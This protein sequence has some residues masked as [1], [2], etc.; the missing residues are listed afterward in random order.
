MEVSP[1]VSCKLVIAELYP[2]SLATSAGKDVRIRHVAVIAVLLFCSTSTRTLNEETKMETSDQ[3]RSIMVM[4]QCVVIN[5]TAMS[6]GLIMQA[7]C[8]V[9]MTVYL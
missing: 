2:K 3:W 8:C 9:K 4:L 5:P 1:E 6:S 7:R